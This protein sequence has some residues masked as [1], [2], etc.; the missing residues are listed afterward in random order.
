VLG[1]IGVGFV[2]GVITLVLRLDDHPR[3]TDNGAVV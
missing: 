1:C 2:A 3:D